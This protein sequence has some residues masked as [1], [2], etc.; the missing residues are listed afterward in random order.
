PKGLPP[1]AASSGTVP[2]PYLR[3]P[4]QVVLLTGPNQTH[5][6]ASGSDSAFRPNLVLTD[7]HGMWFSS[8]GSLWLYRHGELP[9]VADLPAPLFPTP[10]PPPGAAGKGNPAPGSPPPCFPTGVTL[11]LAGACT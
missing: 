9:T 8:P 11:S 7:S 3:P 6:I 1:S 2:T 10:T 5:T 4:P